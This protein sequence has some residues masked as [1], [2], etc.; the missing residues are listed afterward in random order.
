MKNTIWRRRRVVQRFRV[1]FQL[2]PLSESKAASGLVDEAG[3]VV[4]GA[5]GR[6]D[7]FVFG[8]EAEKVG[9]KMESPAG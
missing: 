4:S 6:F 3:G 5:S 8:R 1:F 7:P 9:V 2:D